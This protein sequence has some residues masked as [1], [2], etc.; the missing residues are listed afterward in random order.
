MAAIAGLST[1]R[2]RQLAVEGMPK[3]G[4]EGYPLIS[5]VRW[6]IAYWQKRATPSPLMAARRRKVEADAGSAEFNLTALRSKVAG[7]ETLRKALEAAR[8]RIAT[9]LLAIPAETARQTHHLRTIPEVEAAIRVAIVEALEELSD[10][11]GP[12][13]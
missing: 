2:L 7:A 10:A 11:G 12:A 6:L 8:A 3:A 1:R 13:E 5:C 4:R 9:R